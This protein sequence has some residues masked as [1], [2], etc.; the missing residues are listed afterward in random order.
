MIPT[1]VTENPKSSPWPA[2]AFMIWPWLL[3][4]PLYS[5]GSSHTDLLGT[6]RAHL[7]LRAFVLAIP[8][9]WNILL[10]TFCVISSFSWLGLSS[11]VT[12]ESCSLPPQHSWEHTH[13][14]THTDTL[15]IS[16]CPSSMK[17]YTGSMVFPTVSLL[18]MC[19]KKYLLNACIMN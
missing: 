16:Y 8:S 6:C 19:S 5:P 14:H 10:S 13:I 1:V 9:L 4:C 2:R 17:A 12:S 15:V 7:Y 18:S 3:H 11:T